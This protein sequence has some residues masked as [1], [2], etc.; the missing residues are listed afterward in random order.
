M[1]LR[2]GYRFGLLCLCTTQGTVGWGRAMATKYLFNTI[3][4]QGVKAALVGSLI[5]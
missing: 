2:I 4:V 1:E 5:K 3:P